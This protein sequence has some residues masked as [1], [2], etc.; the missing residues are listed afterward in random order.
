M[1]KLLYNNSG[2]SLRPT[3][4]RAELML[5][6]IHM[7]STTLYTMSAKLEI[8]RIIKL[9]KFNIFG[10]GRFSGRITKIRQARN[11]RVNLQMFFD[12]FLDM[13]SARYEQA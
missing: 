7:L 13:V 4:C 1:S 2:K 5:M 8:I 3:N 6:L 12:S 9:T 11:D 10:N